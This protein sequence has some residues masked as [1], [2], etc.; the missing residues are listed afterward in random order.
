[1]FYR[2]YLLL[3]SHQVVFDPLWPLDFSM[4]GF[5][6]PHHLPE[7]TQIHAHLISDTIQSLHPLLPFFPSAFNLSQHKGLLQWV[8]CFHQV[9]KLLEFQLWHQYFQWIFKVDSFKSV[10]FDL[11]PVQGNLKSLLQHHSLKAS[12]LWYSAFFMVQLSHLYMTTGKTIALTIWNF[13]G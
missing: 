5:P 10:W 11:L 12:I 3:F 7:F 2:K 4:S 1:M 13:V 8:G 9:A 6:V